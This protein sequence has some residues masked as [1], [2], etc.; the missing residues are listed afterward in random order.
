MNFGLI[1]FNFDYL[2]ERK[3]VGNQEYFKTKIDYNNPNNSQFSVETNVTLLQIQ[4]NFI[5]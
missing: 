3:H 4:Q 1:N 5:I 2:E